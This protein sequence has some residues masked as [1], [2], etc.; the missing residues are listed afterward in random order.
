MPTAL[1]VAGTEYAPP[2]LGVS[3]FDKE[4]LESLLSVIDVRIL[5]PPT[6]SQFH[7]SGDGTY[8]PMVEDIA[9]AFN[10]VFSSQPSVEAFTEI[11]KVSE[12]TGGGIQVCTKVERGSNDLV[13]KRCVSYKWLQK[14]GAGLSMSLATA[15]PCCSQYLLSLWLECEADG[16]GAVVQSPRATTVFTLDFRK[17]QLRRQMKGITKAKEAFSNFMGIV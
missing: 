10:L 12:R 2:P 7:S 8:M 3:P 11:S 6:G 9:I 4:A 5:S 1:R 17:W 14:N 13:S 16:S 15:L